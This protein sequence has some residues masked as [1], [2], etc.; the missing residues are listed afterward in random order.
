MLF[1]ENL[2]RLE[3]HKKHFVSAEGGVDRRKSGRWRET[4][5]DWPGSLAAQTLRQDEEPRR[6][7]ERTLRAGE[8]GSRWTG[9]G[10]HGDPFF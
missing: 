5:L 6:P 9:A 7:E 2:T 10:T 4:E 3:Q 1:F 8:R